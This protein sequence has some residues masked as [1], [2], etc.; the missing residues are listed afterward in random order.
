MVY[1]FFLF[2]ISKLTDLASHDI[3]DC[4]GINVYSKIT[5]LP[6]LFKFRQINKLSKILK[7]I[8]ENRYTCVTKNL[9]ENM[10]KNIAH[11]YIGY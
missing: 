11:V 4:H 9:T 6:I 5:E 8:P 3:V 7:K 1:T 10:R 2:T